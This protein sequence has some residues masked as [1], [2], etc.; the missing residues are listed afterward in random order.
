MIGE[1]RLRPGDGLVLATHNRGK[2]EELRVPL[3]QAGL[4]VTDASRWRLTAPVE[5]G[6]DFAANARLKA[7]AAARAT[8]TAAL[9]DDSGF[10]VASIGGAPGVVS[11]R[12]MEDEGGAE[13][14]MRRV[15][16]KASAQT[17]RRA[18]FI[19]V[20]ALAWPDGGTV[21]FQGAVRGVWVWPPRGESGFGYD[22]MFEP[23]GS[24]QTFGE[25]TVAEKRAVSH[26]A[27]A[28]ESLVEWLMD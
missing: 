17:D 27:R 1:R 20:L 19:C 15:H 7:L 28:L 10:E 5:T 11:A 8:C 24:V 26:R 12:W 18:S 23:D 13:A 25:M 6:A 2:I 16:R 4:L 22:P 9:A 3:E 14:A 21:L